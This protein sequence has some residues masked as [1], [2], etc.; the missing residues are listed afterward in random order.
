MLSRR[1][2]AR[3]FETILQARDFGKNRSLPYQDVAGMLSQML[4]GRNIPYNQIFGALKQ[5]FGEPLE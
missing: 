4:G 1:D 3:I 2:D 5:A